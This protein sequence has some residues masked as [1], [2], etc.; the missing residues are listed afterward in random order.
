MNLLKTIWQKRKKNLRTIEWRKRD[1]IEDSEDNIQ[2]NDSAEHLSKWPRRNTELYIITKHQAE[3]DR[4][5]KVGQYSSK[6][7]KDCTPFEISQV[8]RIVRNWLCP[9]KGK[10]TRRAE[11]HKGRKDD[12]AERVDMRDRIQG[13]PSREACSRIPKPF[14]HISVSELVNDD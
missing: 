1:K 14:S 2:I 10:R 6:P 12:R 3:D 4:E 13:E 7:N 8:V 11:E 5:S 9:A